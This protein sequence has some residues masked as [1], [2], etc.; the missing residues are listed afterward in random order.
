M[1]ARPQDDRVRSGC[2][3]D[4][5]TGTVKPRDREQDAGQLDGHEAPGIAAGIHA[6]YAG[7][8]G[9]TADA[10]LLK[11]FQPGRALLRPADSVRPAD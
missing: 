2:D 3:R 9:L 1:D 5:V 11:E 10:A 7:S 8:T 4:A 6:Q